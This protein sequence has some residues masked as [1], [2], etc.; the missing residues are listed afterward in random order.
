SAIHGWADPFPVGFPVPLLTL[1]SPRT[2][3]GTT[4]GKGVTRLA[5]SRGL[6]RGRRL[7]SSDRA[8]AIPSPVRETARLFRAFASRSSIARLVACN[9]A[10]RGG[11]VA[12]GGT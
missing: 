8:W 4:S 3:G 2:W 6:V 9:S 7:R 5:P 11:P 10:G 12:G 1:A